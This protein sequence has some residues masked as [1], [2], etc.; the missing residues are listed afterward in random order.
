MI[1]RARLKGF[2]PYAGVGLGLFFARLKDAGGATSS[3]NGVPGFNAIA[4][5]R[6]FLTDD[7]RLALVVEYNYQRARLNFNNVLDPSL[8]LGTELRGT[9]EAH[10]MMF[11]LSYHLQ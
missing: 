8:G 5:Y 11:G 9:Y 2:E 7:R 6:S 10:T 4:G 1:A 3:D